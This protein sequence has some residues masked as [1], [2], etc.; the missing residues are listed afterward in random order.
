[1]LNSSAQTS[2]WRCHAEESYDMQVLGASAELFLII[3]YSVCLHIE[4]LWKLELCQL[5]F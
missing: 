3:T 5:S 4:V 1:M 2:N